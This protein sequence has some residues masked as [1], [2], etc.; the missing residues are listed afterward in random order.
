MQRLQQR[1]SDGNNS[2][3][4]V[5]E[6]CD[7]NTQFNKPASQQCGGSKMA[8]CTNKHRKRDL[9]WMSSEGLKPLCQIDVC[10]NYLKQQQL[11][12]PVKH[13][14]H[15]SLG[16]DPLP[17]SSLIS[18]SDSIWALLWLDAGTINKSPVEKVEK[19]KRA[20]SSS[21]SPTWTGMAH[22]LG[23]RKKNHMSWL[24]SMAT[25]LQI[26]PTVNSPMEMLDVHRRMILL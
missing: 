13:S 18:L 22:R 7:V 9:V 21:S 23:Q 8:S 6:L 17:L 4:R 19:R 10:R 5:Q 26:W 16:I 1:N 25:R 14:L 12:W 3:E 2:V 15:S 24:V 11:F 20:N